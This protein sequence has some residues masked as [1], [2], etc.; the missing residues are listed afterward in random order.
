MRSTC[1]HCGQVKPMDAFRKNSRCK[2]GRETT[3]KACAA[4]RRRERFRAN[5]EP[6]LAANRAW[7]KAHRAQLNAYRV[8]Y[9]LAH[10][11]QFRAR[12]RRDVAD[13]ADHYVRQLFCEDSPLKHQDIPQALVDARRLAIQ[14]RRYVNGQRKKAA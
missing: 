3:C 4:S 2:N 9:R 11:D 14:I 5:P 6:I 1:K 8:T 12:K 10:V 13:L 7:A